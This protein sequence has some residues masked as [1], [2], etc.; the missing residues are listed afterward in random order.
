MD[1]EYRLQLRLLRDELLEKKKKNIEAP[2]G[3]GAVSW[4]DRKTLEQNLCRTSRSENSEIT[5]PTTSTSSATRSFAACEDAN[6]G[7]ASQGNGIFPEHALPQMTPGDLMLFP[8]QSSETKHVVRTRKGHKKSRAGCFSC[9]NR[10]VPR[11][12]LKVMNSGSQVH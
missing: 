8:S 2:G 10:C 4:S 7:Q 11:G 1:N 3:M 5:S 9:K 12:G 6:Y